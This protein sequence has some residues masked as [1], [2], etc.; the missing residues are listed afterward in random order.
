[1]S[2]E[3]THIFS[4]GHSNLPLEN[5]IEILKLYAISK[6]VDIRSIPR[7]RNNPQFNQENLI[8][9][10]PMESLEYLHMPG[11]GGLRKAKQDSVNTG[12]ENLSFRGYADYMLTDE[13]NESLR[14]LINMA[15]HQKVCLMCAETVPWK[16]HRFLIADSLYI[17]GVE[18]EHILGPTKSRLHTLSS[19]ARPE[20]GRI[21]YSQCV[22]GKCAEK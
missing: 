10:L 21:I 13:F 4:I 5:F 1:M 15:K 17:N 20:N 2:D 6:V 8:L 19:F 22:E 3:R 14:L 7:S 9:R 16:C 11:L 18:T 12:W